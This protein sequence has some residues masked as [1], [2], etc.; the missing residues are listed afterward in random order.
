[1]ERPTVSDRL[2]WAV[3]LVLVSAAVQGLGVLS[4]LK[5]LVR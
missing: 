4:K 3:A 1:M 5:A 2:Q